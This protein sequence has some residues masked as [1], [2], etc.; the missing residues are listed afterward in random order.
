LEELKEFLRIPS[1]S[2]KTEHRADTRRAAEWLTGRMLEAGLA[3]AEVVP[4]AGHPI[5]VGE[6]RKAEGAPTLLIYGHYDVQPPEPLE[7][8]TTP[9]FEPAIRDGRIYARGAVDDKGQLFLYLKAVEA[10]VSARG[11]LPVNVV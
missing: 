6:W 1:V 7:E 9:A 5:V 2:A 10:H 11:S 4:T 8:W 3:S